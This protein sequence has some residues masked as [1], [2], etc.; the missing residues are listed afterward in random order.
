MYVCTYI[1]TYIHTYIVLHTYY[2]H[3]YIHTYVHTN[4][5]IHTYVHNYMFTNQNRY[6]S[7]SCRQFSNCG[8]TSTENWFYGANSNLCCTIRR[9]GRITIILR[10]RITITCR[11]IIIISTFHSIAH[12]NKTDIMNTMIL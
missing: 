11:T 9:S 7:C 4:M 8:H 3:T 2:V 5:Y 6:K 12:C 1:H 10:P